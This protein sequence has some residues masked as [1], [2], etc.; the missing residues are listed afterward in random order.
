MGDRRL[1]I[2]RR[3][4]CAVATALLASCG[5]GGSGGGGGGGSTLTGKFFP[6]DSDGRWFY[7]SAGSSSKV[8]VVGPGTAGGVSGTLVETVD[9]SDGSVID[10]SLYVVAADG[11]RQYALAVADPITQAL[12]GLQILRYPLQAGDSYEQVDT[13]IDLGEDLDGDGRAER[14]ELRVDM[15][16]IGLET[17]T[18]PAGTFSGAL[19]QRQVV[20]ESIKPTGGS[21]RVTVTITLDTW[22]GSDVGPVQATIRI[23]GAGLDEALDNVLTA[24]GVGGRRSE[25]VAPTL[26]GVTPGP[27][28]VR[29]ANATVTAVFSETMDRS[30]VST[31]TFSVRDA[32]GAPVAGS[33]SLQGWTA[34]F[35]PATNS[36]S[37][38]TY[39]ATVAGAEDLV[40]NPTAPRS[41]TFI[42][43]DIAPGVVSSLPAM[44]AIEVGLGSNIVV[45]FSEA[46]D[47]ARVIASNVLLTDDL[48]A[49]HLLDLAL[50]GTRLTVTPTAPLELGRTYRL[51]LRGFADALGNPMPDY[52]LSFR[53]TQ[54]R[55]AFP[56]E[57]IAGVKG[58]TTA[59]GDVNGD[60]IAD[61]LMSTLPDAPA[62]YQ[63]GV[64]L[65]LGRADGT[66]A[67]PTRVDVGPSSSACLTEAIVIGDVNGDGRADVVI[68]SYVC[69]IQVLRQSPAGT[70][71][72]A[73]H[74][75][76]SQASRL[77]LADLDGDGKLDL[78]G[79]GA[80]QSRVGIW[81]RDPSG[82]LVES[83]S[84]QVVFPASDFDI[85]DLDGDGRPDMAFRIG[86]PLTGAGVALVMQQPDGSFVLNPTFLA[87]G[88]PM[89]GVNAI[90]IADVNGD[91]RADVIAAAID[92]VAVFHQGSGGSFVL[93]TLPT[94]IGATSVSVADMNNDGRPDLVITHLAENRVGVSYQQSSGML[95]AEELYVVP[96][97]GASSQQPMALGDV[98]GDGRRDILVNGALLRQ[99]PNGGLA[100]LGS[101][102]RKMPA[103]ARLHPGL[104]GRYGL[105]ASRAAATTNSPGTR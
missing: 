17:V 58:F 29:P 96:A 55:F 88:Q 71:A 5:G 16:V 38:G 72:L 37:S 78:V 94:L 39:T 102:G 80:E 33:V 13:T 61:V 12:D 105:S 4:L 84:F 66:L 3:M 64:F 56:A 79:T 73:E 8:R 67:A 104:L 2:G 87:T 60:G 43:D 83:G 48:G 6:L 44:G 81:K 34:T 41:W 47:P 91:G 70:L 45:D 76:T 95:S 77:R 97:L 31:A 20:R 46:I 32:G 9:E 82:A 7:A 86:P 14:L 54:G 49:E 59:F 65:L 52:A 19:H 35:T 21:D 98:T 15:T 90:A 27:A 92:R 53:T 57:L 69:G 36:W 51:Y 74:L 42:V 11:V 10:Q 100:A 99:N 75:V 63:L 25:M 40:G 50:A 30:S 62:P 68:G 28:A 101:A 22:Y 26:Q 23:V 93:T 24:Y 1:R 89:Y 18:T 103:A 85:G